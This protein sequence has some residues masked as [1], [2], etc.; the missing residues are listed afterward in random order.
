MFNQELAKVSME[1]RE[2][3]LTS[4]LITKAIDEFPF[5]AFKKDLFNIEFINEEYEFVDNY[6]TKRLA[7]IANIS[8]LVIENNQKIGKVLEIGTASGVQSAFLSRIS[9]RIYTIAADIKEEIAVE[10]IF[11]R[12]NFHNIDVSVKKF[13]NGWKE[14]S[15]FDLIVSNIPFDG[16]SEELLSQLSDDGYFAFPYKK[17]NQFFYVI[18]DK[19]KEIKKV[20]DIEYNFIGES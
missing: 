15:P 19:N 14:L 17:E 3:K 16:I 20:F 4:P 10:Q 2:R 1:F 5:D 13:S 11:K 9:H 7:R 8:S 6:Y 12:N 18:I